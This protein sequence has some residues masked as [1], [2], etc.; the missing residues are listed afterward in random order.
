MLGM[1]KILL[2]LAV[3][4]G[5][6]LYAFGLSRG[7]TDRPIVAPSNSNTDNPADSSTPT[8]NNSMMSTPMP[9]HQTYKNGNFTSIV[10]DAFYG[11]VQIRTTIKAGRVTDIQ[12]LQ[13]PNDRGNSIEINSY[14][15][16]I[17]RTEAIQAQNA[18]VDIV[19]GATAT[20]EAFR[21]ALANTLSQAGG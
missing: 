8:N 3:I 4:F 9:M 13:Y 21:Q 2:S 19:S 1:N 7:K 5:F 10:T 18:A 17:L 6:G 14:A 20:S 15:M 12:F 16:P 11:N